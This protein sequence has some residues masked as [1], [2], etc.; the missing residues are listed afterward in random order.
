V[1]CT[2]T[3][4]RLRARKTPAPR[5]LLAPIAVVYKEYAALQAGPESAE[6]VSP[7]RTKV[8]PAGGWDGTPPRWV[9][10]LEV[11]LWVPAPE[12]EKLYRHYQDEFL[13]ENTKTKERA[14]EAAAFAWRHEDRQWP[15]RWDMWNTEHPDKRFESWRA[16]REYALRGQRAALPR[17]KHLR[18]P[19][20]RD[21]Y[22]RE[23]KEA[24]ERKERLIADLKAY[25][26]KTNNARLFE[27]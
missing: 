2:S 21:T 14:F 12:I 10:D 15:V 11:E 23:R 16:F 25:A 19:K 1:G 13:A 18:A 17:Y 22:L 9:L 5:G 20:D 27:R 4:R 8:R 7:F 3:G 6:A 24:R 26:K